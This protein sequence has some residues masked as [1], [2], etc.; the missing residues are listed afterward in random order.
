[1]KIVPLDQLDF[2]IAPFEWSWAAENKKS[3][4]E[5]FIRM[6]AQRPQI[7]NGRILML[8]HCEVQG[9]KISGT[10]FE[11]DF[12]NLVAFRAAGF[13]DT[14][15]RTCAASSALL[16][17]DGAY[18]LGVM[19][20]YT[21]N[22]GRIYFIAGTPDTGDVL[23]DGRVDL[24]ASTVKELGEEAGLS[25]SDVRFAGEWHAVLTGARVSLIRVAH[26]AQSEETLAARIRGFIASQKEPEL[27]DVVA[28]RAR[29]DFSPAMPD[30]IRAYLNAMLPPEAA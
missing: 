30:F 19:A 6:R 14:G 11:T 8:N 25:A 22:A 29:A 28:V 24:A 13:P 1:V 4:D 21:A 3:I 16:T 20:P 18:L 2:R 27:S 15:V 5:H 7:W 10:F 12:A 23:A 9:G 26:C 17:Q